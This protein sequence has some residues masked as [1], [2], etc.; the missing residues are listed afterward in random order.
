MK[1]IERRAIPRYHVKL[2]VDVTL[3]NSTIQGGTSAEASFAGIQIVCEGPIAGKLLNK[4]IQVTPG[5]NLIAKLQI[6]IL[7]KNGIYQIITCGARVVSVNRIS[8]SSYKVGFN[9]LEF[10]E[11]DE[12][13]WQNFISTLR[14]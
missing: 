12:V 7:N 1:K 4:Y 8:Q 11:G 10:E 3:D 13:Y 9:F 5:K 2:A 14:G 6:K